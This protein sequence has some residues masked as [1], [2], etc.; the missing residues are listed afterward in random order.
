MLNTCERYNFSYFEPRAKAHD[1]PRVWVKISGALHLEST[2]R[3]RKVG[4]AYVAGVARVDVM[5]SA[6][7]PN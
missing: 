2:G 7:S 5:A 1:P 6:S 4:V 3:E